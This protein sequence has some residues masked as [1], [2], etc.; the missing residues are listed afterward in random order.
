[1][2]WDSALNDWVRSD[3][4]L[5]QVTTNYSV[6]SCTHLST[7]TLLL[8]LNGDVSYFISSLVYIAQQETVRPVNLPIIFYC[9]NAVTTFFII[10]LIISLACSTRFVPNMYFNF[11]CF[12]FV[13]L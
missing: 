6:C 8:Q 2:I 11:L 4:E 9:S 13:F 5:V 3:C 10:V 7:Y 12:V 1:M